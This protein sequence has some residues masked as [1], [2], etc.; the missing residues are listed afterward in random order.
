M[1]KNKGPLWDAPTEG[2]PAA[3]P[4]SLISTAPV[5]AAPPDE[6]ASAVPAEPHPLEAAYA[7]ITDETFASA[8]PEGFALDDTAKAALLEALNGGETRGDIAK[9]LLGLYQKEVEKFTTASTEAWETVQ[10][11]WQEEIRQAP[12]FAGAKLEPALARAKETALQ[13]GGPELLNLLDVTGMGN[14]LVALKALLKAS[15]L[16]PKEGQPVGG[17]PATAPKSLAEKLFPSSA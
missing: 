14:N 1:H 13:L 15:E 16:I 2:A 17:R 11:G 9:N 12:E 7:P 5:A 3:E 8:L 10:K 6:G 4:T